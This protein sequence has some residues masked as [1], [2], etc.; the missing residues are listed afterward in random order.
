MY[1]QYHKGVMIN[2]ADPFSPRTSP[3]FMYHIIYKRRDRVIGIRKR[4]CI[5]AWTILGKGGNDVVKDECR[6]RHQV[7][8]DAI[9]SIFFNRYP[10]IASG[11]IEK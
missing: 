6:E 4:K 2:T 11:R 9:V 1:Q 10:N 7:T 3:F 5:I 8:S